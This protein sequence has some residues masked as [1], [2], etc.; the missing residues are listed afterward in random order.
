M[1]LAGTQICEIP[2][3]A[4]AAFEQLPEQGF[5]IKLPFFPSNVNLSIIGSCHID[6]GNEIWDEWNVDV[7]PIQRISMCFY[8][9]PVVF[10]RNISRGKELCLGEKGAKWWNLYF[11]ARR[12]MIWWTNTFEFFT[13][14]SA[15][16]ITFTVRWEKAPKPQFVS[17]LPLHPSTRHESWLPQC[18]T[19]MC[20]MQTKLYFC[21][22]QVLRFKK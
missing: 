16:W 21:R 13:N 15:R 14:K 12:D 17:F 22:I 1:L 4:V 18:A 9:N 7:N 5:F 19:F 20:D 3:R 10:F 8:R 6:R 11:R 2:G